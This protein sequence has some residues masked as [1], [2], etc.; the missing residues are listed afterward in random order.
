VAGS[1]AGGEIVDPGKLRQRAACVPG[2]KGTVAPEMGTLTRRQRA[3]AWNRD[4]RQVRL[5]RVLLLVIVSSLAV[6]SL[7][8][9]SRLELDQLDWVDI[10]WIPFD[11]GTDAPGGWDRAVLLVPVKTGGNEYLFQLD[12]GAGNSYLNRGVADSEGLKYELVRQLEASAVRSSWQGRIADLELA[13]LRIDVLDIL[14]HELAADTARE[15]VE[16]RF[17][18]EGLPAPVAGTIGTDLL[19]S[20]CVVL[21]LEMGR[22]ALPKRRPAVSGLEARFELWGGRPVL[23]LAGDPPLR[24]I[25][26]TGSSAFSLICGRSAFEQLTGGVEGAWTVEVTGQTGVVGL[27]AAQCET[28]L[29]IGAIEVPINF[30]CGTA[31]VDELA[32]VSGGQV[33]AIIG[34]EVFRGKVVILDFP[35]RVLVVSDR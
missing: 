1:E 26:D 6:C 17:G 9:C 16:A 28:A 15:K 31:L 13:G 33:N 2:G 32:A 11:P 19:I 24:A 21:D 30:L 34:N 27:E 14:V 20:R 23:K 35:A 12:T 18:G 10:T 29:R 25:Y 3:G 7:C 22:F 5:L 4:S 8:S